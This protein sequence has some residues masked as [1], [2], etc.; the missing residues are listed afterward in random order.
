MRLR[1]ARYIGGSWEGEEFV[2]QL[3]KEKRLHGEI[4]AAALDGISQAYRAE[5]R[6]AADKYLDFGGGAKSIFE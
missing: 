4:K 6:K 1:A 3:L 2:L 5:I